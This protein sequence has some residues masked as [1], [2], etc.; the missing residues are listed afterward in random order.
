MSRR[1]PTR[2]WCC[3]RGRTAAWSNLGRV[4]RGEVQV[5]WYMGQSLTCDGL[6]SSRFAEPVLRP[7]K[8]EMD[9]REMQCL[10]CRGKGKVR[11]KECPTCWGNR[12]VVTNTSHEAFKRA[13]AARNHHYVPQW[14][15]KEFRNESGQLWYFSRQKGRVEPRNTESVFKRRGL[16]HAHNERTGKVLED[17]EM[18]AAEVDNSLAVECARV[19]ES[20]HGRKSDRWTAARNVNRKVLD[21]LP[22]R[23]AFARP[24]LRQELERRARNEPR[25]IRGDKTVNEMAALEV[26]SYYWGNPWEMIHQAGLT[27]AQ[28]REQV[29]ITG[30]GAPV[31]MR[32]AQGIR[33]IVPIASSL[34]LVWD[35][36]S[37]E[38]AANHIR[39]TARSEKMVR[40]IN[41]RIAETSTAIVGRNKRDIIALG[42][43]M[44]A[45]T[46]KLP[47]VQQWIMPS[48]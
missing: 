11:G 28:A 27:I 38:R 22:L 1:P 2:T 35:T 41:R 18:R 5:C 40:D 16:N 6:A 42:R 31:W 29:F 45:G 30:D 20:A 23:L 46:Q 32:N 15:L 26:M 25:A 13:T 21:C 17:A 19:T 37:E 24:Q 44:E 8:R 3:C 7:G 43:E 47:A 33:I 14:L 36:G 9:E 10:E 34:A 48:Y 12:I 39:C 4:H